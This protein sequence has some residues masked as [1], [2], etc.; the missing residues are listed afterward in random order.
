MGKIENTAKAKLLE[1]PVL[2][3]SWITQAKELIENFKCEDALS[4]LQA[5][6]LIH[7]DN[8]WIATLEDITS[9]IVKPI[10]ASKKVSYISEQRDQLRQHELDLARFLDFLISEDWWPHSPFNQ[11]SLELENSIS[12]SERDFLARLDNTSEAGKQI[13]EDETI[14]L[15]GTES[16]RLE[17][18]SEYETISDHFDHQFYTQSYGNRI[19]DLFKSSI[20]LLGCHYLVFGEK[21]GLMPRRDFAPLKYLDANE[22]VKYA[23]ISAFWHWCV[24][25]QKEG[26]PKSKASHHHGL[27]NAKEIYTQLK[28]F[29]LDDK[30]RSWAYNE[31]SLPESLIINH[32][33]KGECTKQYNNVEIIITFDNFTANAGG[34]QQC[35]RDAIAKSLSSSIMPIIFFPACPQP[36]IRTVSPLI[37]IAIGDSLL[38]GCFSINTIVEWI[39]TEII[40][41]FPNVRSLTIHSLL[42]W[43]IRDI[44]CIHHI[45]CRN[46]RPQIA[47]WLHD[48]FLFCPSYGA[49][50]NDLEQC[51]LAEVDS[52]ECRICGYREERKKAK[53]HIQ[54]LLN[55]AKPIFISPS[56]FMAKKS[57]ILLEDIY[58]INDASIAVQEHR[59]IRSVSLKTISKHKGYLKIGF[60][61]ASTRMK[62]WD[63]FEQL[64]WDLHSFVEISLFCFSCS[65]PQTWLPIKWV[66]TDSGESLVSNL[67]CAGIH[68]V[69]LMSR[70]PETFGLTAYEALQAGS[71]LHTHAQSGNIAN[72]VASHSCGAVHSNYQSLLST[73]QSRAMKNEI[74]VY[75]ADITTQGAIHEKQP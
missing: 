63:I 18:R 57:A 42:G 66:R 7:A 2:S 49:Q 61:G 71:F 40:P 37:R 20:L 65:A 52:V 21:V 46:S 75:S 44:L 16:G 4:I 23:K 45:L 54:E 15:L 68:D 11:A 72:L 9:C 8:I 26:R 17:L 34:I 28:S 32:R 14:R 24:A 60:L 69:I 25:G 19:H 51:Q 5:A 59:I 43:D 39:A 6:K 70:A 73:I 38:D 56:D 27:L 3:T 10:P 30:K 22:D 53:R 36:T 58:G 50:R 48:Q 74:D 62:G 12:P 31:G 33:F 55:Q 13:S 64:C 29:S 1:S 35:I 47:I 67:K 41:A